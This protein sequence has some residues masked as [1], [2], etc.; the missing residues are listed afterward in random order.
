MLDML[1]CF[2]P[3]I[4]VNLGL[5]LPVR[6]GVRRIAFALLISLLVGI[7]G[8]VA[9]LA[10]FR[11]IPYEYEYDEEK[12]Y[13]A[14]KWR[15]IS[16]VSELPSGFEYRPDEGLFVV[17]PDSKVQIT[18][19]PPVCLADGKVALDYRKR[20]SPLPIVMTSNLRAQLPPPP[21]RPLYHV[22]FDVPLQFA[23]NTDILAASGFAAYENGEIWCTERWVQRGVGVGAA[24]GIAVTAQALGNMIIGF[25]GSSFVAF[26][27]AIVYLEIR[28]WRMNVTVR[29]LD[30]K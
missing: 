10:I 16:S 25:E 3:G 27:V 11:L 22:T 18:N 6:Y 17:T 20:S 28:L 30:A 2:L 8:A 15:R 21:G 26:L 12:V 1:L 5:I 13:P 19:I 24:I 14:E 9:G 7:A 23:N 29:R 4:V